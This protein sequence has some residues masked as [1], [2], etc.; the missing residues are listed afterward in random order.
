MS[1]EPLK[2][3]VPLGGVQ[4]PR[5]TVRRWRWDSTGELRSF[6]VRCKQN[7]WYL[8]CGFPS[9]NR[10]D[11]TAQFQINFLRGE[12]LIARR[13]V[14]MDRFS[15]GGTSEI[16]LG[17]VMAPEKTTHLQI[18]L[19]N[20]QGSRGFKQVVLHPVSDRDPKCHPLAAVPRWSTYQP[21]F[22]VERVVLPKSLR[23]LK[24]VI[25]PGTKIEVV[26]RP[27][28]V[29]ELAARAIGAACILAPEWVN[30]LSL[31]LHD[32]EQIAA[33]SWFMLDIETFAGLLKRSGQLNPRIVT[34]T[35]EHEIMSARIEYADVATR[36]FALED[37]VPYATL[38]GE[39][40]FRTRVLRVD[41]AWKQY[42]RETG[43]ALLL[44]SET[45]WVNRGGDLLSG[46]R[47]IDCG[48]LVVTDLPWLIAG[49]WGRLAAPRL[50]EHLL[51]MHLCG[52]HDDAVQYWT[53]WNE[54]PVVV[55]DI[56][57][58][59][60]RY[61]PMRTLRWA[62]TAEGIERLGLSVPALKR[63][64]SARHLMFSTG[65]IDQA[66]SHDGL[67]PEP[68]EIFMKWLVRERREC[69]SWAEKYLSDTTVTWQ[70]DTAEGLKYASLYNSA[71]QVAMPKPR[72]ML[73]LHS[74]AEAGTGGVVRGEG[75]HNTAWRIPAG[76]G[77]FGDRSHEYQADLTRRLR[78]WIEGRC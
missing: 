73:Y 24:G 39:T 16:L 71:A 46:A 22:P 17:W 57:E 26:E 20:G 18:E 54:I 52:P 10:S 50:A 41:Q 34:H 6:P 40:K 43:F 37:V 12:E 69:T 77:I 58:L 60:R 55:R 5:Q 36:G 74:D 42:A 53:R 13:C 78:G 47:S 65:R 7:Q 28:S 9:E 61:P 33:A 1:L 56:G 14:R 38:A 25:S 32:V 59:P 70:F 68:F 76:A 64:G 44:A 75:K 11:D 19:P 8:A 63:S 45:P 4:L 72:N 2:S 27:R 29:R 51:R 3:G 62:P 21:P 67:P 66:G 35:S 23:Q 49:R 48:M 31:S 15:E 30:D